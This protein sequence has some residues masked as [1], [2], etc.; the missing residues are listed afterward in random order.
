MVVAW[1]IGT[2]INVHPSLKDPAP[3]LRHFSRGKFRSRTHAP[4]SGPWSAHIVPS[5]EISSLL[6]GNNPVLLTAI[7]MG[8]QLGVFQMIRDHQGE[9]ATTEQIASQS[10]A[11]LIVVDQILR[12]LTAAGYVS[13]AGVQTYKPS[14]LTMA[15]ADGTLEAMTRACFDI[16][17]YCSTYAPEY[18][19]Q[20]NNQFPTSAEDTPFQLAKKTPLSYFEWLGENPSLAKDFQQ[21]MTLKQQATPN[22]VDWFDVRGNLLHGFRNRPDDVLLVDVGG[23]EGHYLH[24]FNDKY[25]DAPGRRI[26]QDLPQVISTIN[27]TPKDTELMAHDFFT[28]QPVKG[29]RAYY[30]HWILHD[31]RD[32]QAHSILSHIVDA[33]E[34]GYSKLIINDQIIPD[35]DCDFATA[36]ISIMMM[37]QVGAF[38]RTEKQWRA[39]LTSVG[40][41]DVSFYQPPGNGE[42]I[43]V[44]TKA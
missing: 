36:C 20:N 28:V 13:E 9:G 21:W 32:E 31:W 5:K 4:L 41:K 40:L 3:R 12:L 7:R 43:I 14:P 6:P 16:G 26:L 10:G 24:A 8:V 37:L 27:K 30:M 18:F 15:M 2:A 23:G 39:L 34:P 35:R 29:A 25:P 11:S 17:N 44:A 33:M 1:E 42:G 38:E 22:W 19:R